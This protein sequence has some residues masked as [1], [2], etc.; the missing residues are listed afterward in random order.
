MYVHLVTGNIELSTTKCDKSQE[1]MNS[2]DNSNYYSA[3][4][5]QQSCAKQASSSNSVYKVSA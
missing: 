3:V 4:G 2:T 5:N 1:P